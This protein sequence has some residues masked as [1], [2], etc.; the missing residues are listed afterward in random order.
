MKRI[1]ARWPIKIAS[2]LI[3]ANEE[4]RVATLE[5]MIRIFP[6]ITFKDKSN[7]VGVIFRDF[8]P[9]LVHKDQIIVIEN[10]VSGKNDRKAV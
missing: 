8:G 10:E 4:G 6:N 2:T 9:C 1:K 7:F 5:E 3:P